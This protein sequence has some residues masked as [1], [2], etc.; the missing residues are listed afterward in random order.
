MFFYRKPGWAIGFKVMMVFLLIAG[1]T[2]LARSAFQAGFLQGAAVDGGEITMPY[3]YPHSRG[4]SFYPM[5]GS[6]LPFLAIFFGGILLV[7]LIS[8]IVGFV[9]FKSWKT[10]AGPDWEDWKAMKYNRYGPHGHHCR[11]HYPCL[12]YTSPSPR[13]RS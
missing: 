13:D 2:F 7:K 9:M 4:F 11:P 3:F 6:F 8:S 10:E 12:L 5:G 1:G